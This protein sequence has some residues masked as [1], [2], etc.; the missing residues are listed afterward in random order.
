MAKV[1]S[2]KFQRQENA[3]DT[4]SEKIKT[5]DFGD[6]KI[7][8]SRDFAIS[9]VVFE[10]RNL[11]KEKPDGVYPLDEIKALQNWMDSAEFS[12]NRTQEV[13]VGTMSGKTQYA[14]DAL[15]L[16]QRR[17]ENLIGQLALKSLLVLSMLLFR[18]FA[19]KASKESVS[20]SRRT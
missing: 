11:Y 18:F 14:M 10:M 9:P 12:R 7:S 4:L 13:S 5:G 19:G 2:Q 8:V 1:Y 15:R 3:F 16:D 17:V 20:F 6:G